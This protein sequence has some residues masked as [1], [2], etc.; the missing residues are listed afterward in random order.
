MDLITIDFE[1]CTTTKSIRS[2]NLPLKNT[3]EILDL[4]SLA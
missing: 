2:R 1:T 4:K 3:S